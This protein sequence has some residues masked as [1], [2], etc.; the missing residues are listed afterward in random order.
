[1]PTL[2]QMQNALA[3]ADASGDNEDA[4]LIA[5]DIRAHPTFQQNAKGALDSGDYKYGA[6]GMTELGKDEQRANMSKQMA[7]SMGLKDSEVDVTQGMGTYGRFKLSFQ[8]TEKD[9]V[10]HLEDTYGRENI[11]ATEVGGKMK[12]LYRDEQETGGQFRA[13]DEEGVSLADFFG[14]TAGTAL[15]IAGAVGAAVATGGASIPLMAG[16]AALGGLAAGVGQDTAV[17]AASGEDLQLG[18]SFK[19]RG[20]EAA[21]GVPIDLV[22]G[23]LAKGISG[24]I[25]RNIADDLGGALTRAETVLNKSEAIQASGGLKLTPDMRVGTK[26]AVEDASEIA[27]TRQNSKIAGQYGRVRD[28]IAAYKKAATEGVTDTGESFGKA[29]QRIAGEYKTLI[30]DVAKLDKEA[31]SELS[32]SLSRRMN[33]LAAKDTVNMSKLGER[34]VKLF[35]GAQGKV[36][37]QNADNFAEIG[38]MAAER[39]ISASN[40]QVERAISGALRKFK[41]KD[42]AKVSE[43]LSVVKGKVASARRAKRIRSNIDS[44]KVKNTQAIQKE[45]K[46]LDKDSVAMDFQTVREYIE[47]IQDA[48][49]TAGAVGGKTEAQVASVSADA[50]RRLRDRIAKA[51]GDDFATAYDN[52][53]KFY[54]D[55]VLSY[56]RGPAGKA[57]A[58]KAGA[59]AN[60]P[61]DVM[62]D[63]LSDP[64]KVKQ[65]LDSIDPA[66]VVGRSTAQG[67]LREAFLAKIGMDGTTDLSNGVKLSQSDRDV[68]AELFGGSR[69]KSFDTLNEIVR[70]TKGADLS[71]VTKE[72]LEEVLSG[73]GTDAVKSISRKIAARTAKETRAKE[74]ADNVIIGGIIRGDFTELTP[75]L[76]ADALIKGNPA[77][78]KQAMSQILKGS[79][80][81]IASVRQEYVS[82]FFAKY[83]GGAQLD[84]AG[85][86]IWNPQALARDLAGNNGKTIKANMEAVLGKKQ[87]SEILAA[88]EVL[89]AG[90]ALSKA[91]APDIKPRF[92]FSPTNIAGYFVGDIMGSVRHRIMGWAYGTESLIPLMKLMSKKVSQEDFEKSFSKII[93]PMLASEKGIMAMARE[94]DSDP[95]F[96]E[97]ANN[98]AASFS[99]QAQ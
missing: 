2:E 45:L 72:E 76:F 39:G 68:V 41:I 54:T 81:E 42:N 46:A 62:N 22:T 87:T 49:P 70:R 58:Q 20:I 65:A 66:D 53:N 26:G 99:G 33:K 44:G 28:N 25:G 78:V 23:G 69:L 35:E 85:A 64:T 91:S 36:A 5:A 50:V 98:A 94:G 1:M 18:E 60:T 12:L 86:G 71:K 27:A 16:A 34:W 96:Q 40:E 77:K 14:D 31:A 67:E 7:R 4:K 8:P 3:S 80:D 29:A 84:S 48:V 21:I 55:K 37:S 63:I 90:S 79:D 52:A 13:V 56:K 47:K 89:D 19:R 59:A 97:A 30:D 83:S 43:I 73:L 88:N 92:I 82:Q 9:K 10:K 57:L 11:R 32:R 93:A 75:H 38:R 24:K 15:P 17:R 51:G 74:L 6:D 61:S 95:S